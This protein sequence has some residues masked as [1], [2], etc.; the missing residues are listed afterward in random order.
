[1]IVKRKLEMDDGAQAMIGLDV[2][3][4]DK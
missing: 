3:R 4:A 2:R 1:M